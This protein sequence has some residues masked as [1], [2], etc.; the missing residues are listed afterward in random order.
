MSYLSSTSPPTSPLP[1]PRPDSEIEE[2]DQ[3]V[4]FD[5]LVIKYFMLFFGTRGVARRNLRR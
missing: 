2:K 4:R 1:S 5:K 3:I